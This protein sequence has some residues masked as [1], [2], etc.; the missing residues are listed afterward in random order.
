MRVSTEVVWMCLVAFAALIAC[1]PALAGEG[2]AVVPVDKV[3]AEGFIRDWLVVGGFPNE[4]V[5]AP[6]QE[7]AQPAPGAPRFRRAAPERTSSSGYETDLLAP[8]GG[9][10]AGTFAPDEPVPYKTADGESA[11]AQPFDMSAASNGFVDLGAAFDN[12][13][14]TVAYATCKVQADKDMR[15]NAYFGSDDSAKVW[16]NGK[17]V[18]SI[19]VS[20]RG[21]ERWNENFPVDLHAGDNDLLV[22]VEQNTGG[23]GFYLEL[24]TD[25]DMKLARIGR[26]EGVSFEAPST[27]LPAGSTAV[28]GTLKPSPEGAAVDLHAA[29]AL[30]DAS[31]RCLGTS[32][33]AQT[34]TPLSLPL[35]AGYHGYVEMRYDVYRKVAPMTLSGDARLYVG[36]LAADKA[37]L[38]E[39]AHSVAARLKKQL[40]DADPAKQKA[41]RRQLPIARLAEEWLPFE[42]TNDDSKRLE[43]FADLK[44]AIEAMAKGEDYQLHHAGSLPQILDLPEGMSMPAMPY[45]VSLPEGYTEGGPWPVI[46]HL[47]GSGGRNP[48]TP[49][50]AHPHEG[51][52][53]NYKFGV[54]MPYI[55]ITP[56]TNAGWD[57]AILDKLLDHVLDAYNADPDR[58]SLT[59]FSMG[60]MGTYTW[61]CARPD[62]F[63]A[64][65][66]LSGNPRG[67]DLTK[68]ADLPIWV[69][70]GMR[71]P[72]VS[73]PA[74]EQ[75]VKDLQALGANVRHTFFPEMGHGIQANLQ[76]TED[77]WAWLAS[78]RRP[79]AD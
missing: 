64:L 28:R 36:D 56:A 10:S 9:E 29:I 44:P 32:A 61:A 76:H 52:M 59:G 46:I 24:Y 6:G 13:Q 66:I 39:Q 7:A 60:G 62:R 5:L 53:W 77:F 18:H 4:D 72:A 23:W 40:D 65:A 50:L 47:H 57:D 48:W 63:A 45:W 25:A 26:I 37:A 3:T 17:L 70:H 16:V 1:V 51:A 41:A 30:Y 78:F 71:D 31:G 58:V 55:C 49:N 73:F 54:P 19:W 11:T 8:V 67:N 21:A 79:K 12:A 15:V 20:S 69:C 42:F 68:I 2:A 75:T 22:K 27:V 34:D 74:A 43:V 38:L 33:G 14:H 35:P